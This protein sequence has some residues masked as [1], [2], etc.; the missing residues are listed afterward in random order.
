MEDLSNEADCE[1]FGE[2]LFDGIP[3]VVGKTAKMLSFG[4]SFRIDVE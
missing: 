3:S 1:Y 4:G 2:F